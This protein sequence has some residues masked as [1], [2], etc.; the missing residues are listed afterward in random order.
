M[1]RFLP[2]KYIPFLILLPKSLSEAPDEGA[3]DWVGEVFIHY[4]YR[5]NIGWIVGLFV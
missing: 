2:I 4:I 3:W 5:L 1:Y